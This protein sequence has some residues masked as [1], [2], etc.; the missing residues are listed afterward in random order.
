MIDFIAEIGAN[1]EGSLARA[2]D[3][4]ALA[5]HSGATTV[6]FQH[7]R[8]ATLVSR[9]GFAGLRLAHQRDWD[10]VYATFERYE[11]P[12]AWTPALA[13]CCQEHGVEFL[14]SPYDVALINAI[15]PFCRR[16]KV[17]SGE[18]THRALLQ[19]IAATGKP[20]LLAT[21]ASYDFEVGAACRAIRDARGMGDRI[22]ITLMQCTTNYSGD[23]ANVRHCNLL[24]M[25]RMYQE[26]GFGGY[27][28][29]TAVGL[30][31]HTRSLP[32]AVAAVALGATV[33]ERHFTDDRTRTGS[34]DH[35]F[36]MEPTDWRDMVDACLEAEQA[37]GWSVKTVSPI[38]EEARIVQR[39]GL[40]GGQALRPCL[41]GHELPW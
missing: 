12:L 31:D 30:S 22:P 24:A 33:I 7:F 34:P 18:I 16:W 32:V 2:C 1:H 27:P 19:A 26:R 15:E 35:P 37:L 5:A 13:E 3:L 10:D 28:W 11:T 39:R 29:V 38:E 17:G 4:I 14:T 25:R 40:W 21:G 9:E 20:V 41:P 6:K 36:A 8:A 23:P